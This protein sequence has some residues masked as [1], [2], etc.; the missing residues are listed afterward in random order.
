MKLAIHGGMAVGKTTLI[1]SLEKK[2]KDYHYSFEDISDV[3][4][5]VTCLGLN[6]NDYTDYLLN[7][8]LFIKHEIKRYL[9]LNEG[10]TIMDYSAEEVAFQTLTF[11][12]VYHPEWPK[13]HIE[14]L[15]AS[16]LPYYADHILYL[17]AHPRT[18]KLRKNH[19]MNRKR[20]SFDNYI[21][22]IHVLKREWFK[23]LGHAAFVDTTHMT[24][25][26]VFIF[27]EKWLEGIH[28]SVS[29]QSKS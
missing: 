28:E 11:P 27:T 29:R 19:D 9:N 22:G 17:D 2:Y 15:A 3:V 8:D 21:H 26:E 13:A 12:K 5:K 4:R 6:K 24:E 14:R 16:L 1:K 7:Q 25:E 20:N 10:I 18:L 23:T